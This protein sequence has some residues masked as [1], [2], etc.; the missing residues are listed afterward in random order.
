MLRELWDW[1]CF[2][3]FSNSAC[4]ASGRRGGEGDGFANESFWRREDDGEVWFWLW[5]EMV[6]SMR[7]VE[8][9]R[10]WWVRMMKLERRWRDIFLSLFCWNISMI[11]LILR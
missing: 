11:V 2:W 5:E 10:R 1:D 3:S 9:G 7:I 8:G 6:V 4:S